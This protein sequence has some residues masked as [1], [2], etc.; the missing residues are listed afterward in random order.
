MALFGLNIIFFIA[1]SSTPNLGALLVYI[2]QYSSNVMCHECHE[3]KIVIMES[4]YYE[5]CVIG[6]S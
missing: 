5:S 6:L 1:V 4:C 3:K 2:L